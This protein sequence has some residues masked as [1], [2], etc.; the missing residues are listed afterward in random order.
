M[1][2]NGVTEAVR[3]PQLWCK[4][5]MLSIFDDIEVMSLREN[6]ILI[7]I[8]NELFLQTL[9]HF[10][11][12]NS[13]ELN[14]R[15]QRKDS[16]GMQGANL[17]S[18]R[19]AS[20]ALFYSATNAEAKT[21]NHTFRI[22]VKIIKGADDM[23]YLKE[24]EINKVDL[25]IKLPNE[26]TSI[27]RRLQKFKVTSNNLLQIHGSEKDG[28]KLRFILEEAEKCKITMTWN[29][30]L[31]FQRMN[32]STSKLQPLNVPLFTA[33]HTANEQ[34]ETEGTTEISAQVLVKLRD[35][36]LSARLA[37]TCKNVVLL[38]TNNQSC[39]LHCLLNDTDKIEI[40]YYIEAVKETN[41][42][43]DEAY[44]S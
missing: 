9:R 34:E 20:L 11:R 21:I 22:P 41:L 15:L 27:Y 44:L 40:I 32:S 43:D 37:S 14:I 10:D 24:P 29:Y 28:G 12:S 5:E 7:E 23:P 26:F 39:V 8:N 25:M 38:I 3:E 1:I 4:L 19:T 16:L 35:W 33:E 17:G 2:L 31:R 13:E 42:V 30:L 18:N 6:V 36:N